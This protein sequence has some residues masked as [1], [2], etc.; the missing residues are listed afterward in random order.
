MNNLIEFI[1]T[2]YEF[3]AA[4]VTLSLVSLAVIAGILSFTRS[5]RLST[6]LFVM[7]ALSLFVDKSFRVLGS[8]RILYINE[9]KLGG[10]TL[11]S[12]AVSAA[13]ALFLLAALIVLYFENRKK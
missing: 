7:T 3:F 13:P 12:D 10:L 1:R 8:L 4:V 2:D 5:R 11:Y 6:L 9:F